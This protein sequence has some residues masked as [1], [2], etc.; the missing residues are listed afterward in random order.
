MKSGASS[1]IL[2]FIAMITL[3]FAGCGKKSPAPGTVM[4]EAMTAGRKADSFPA[5]DEDYFKDMD[6]GIQL[7][8]NEVKGRNNW[9]VW[10][11]GNDRFWDHLV[12]KSFGAVDFLK[13][14]SSH[15]NVK[16]LSRDTRWKYLGLVN[17]PCFEKANGAR[18]DR[19]GLWLDIR[20]KD[21]PPD[22]F[23]NEQKYPG[24]KIGARGKNM[25][26]GSYYGY[27]TGIVGLRLFPNPDFDEAAAKKW[28]PERFYTD[29]S[30]YNDKNLIRPYRVGMSCGFCHVGPSPV[31]PPED[32]ESP[33]WENLNSN[34]GAQYFWVDRILFWDKDESSFVY[35]LL[36]TSLPGTLD[37][38]FI[39]SD[40]INNP[41]TMN[42]LYSVGPR[43]GP[44]LRWGQEKLA[45]GNLKNKQ[46]QDFPQTAAL[47]QFYKAPD[48]V[49]TPRV[50]KDGSD[51]VGILGALNRV[52]INIGLFSEEW[53]LHFNA[54]VG[55]KEITP[56]KIEDA[57]KNS[58]YWNATVAQT[59]DV[60]LFFL[61]SAKPDLL[62]DAP[63]GSQYLTQD[64]ARLNRGKVAFAERCARCHSSKIPEAPSNVD[65][66]NWEQYW[67]WTKT[68]DFKKKMTEMVLADDFLTDNY[69][70]TERRIPVT[71]LQ[72]NACSPL[73]TNAIAGN[74][75]DNFSSQTYQTLP[76]VGKVTL[77]N[78][79]DGTT[80]DYE[81]PGGGRGFTRP[82]SLISL[83]STAPFLLNNSVG[84]FRWEASVE[85]RMDSFT[86]AIEK[87]LWPEKREKD[88]ILGDKVPGFIYRTTAT[89]YIK[90][91]PGFL[92]PRLEKL[93]SW[94]DWLYRLFP[95]LFSEGI[96]MIGPIPKGTPVTLLTNIDLE[97]NR[98]DL[99]KVLLKMKADLKQVEGASDEE[100]AKVF[101]NLVPD[102]LKVSKCPDYV[103]NKGHYFGTSSFKE[104][105]ALSDDDKW[106][107][108]E[109]LKTF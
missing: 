5:A 36:H 74:I 67:A 56:I 77:H 63:G 51:S 30:Y 41:R 71:L 13:I 7:T 84:K 94:G 90:V 81:L 96:V 103:V 15:P 14:L 91:A 79:I 46:F 78:P 21:C 44:A 8:T 100:A 87:M 32:P 109:Y 105:P 38:S 73:A 88:P 102:L 80:F 70:S 4:D 60:A 48:T 72:T 104:E 58:S 23:E 93:L 85:A 43:L 101:K 1:R 92:P 53:L 55:G 35:Q 12:N 68:D 22:P 17:E 39:S 42:A 106:A 33:K 10:T 108:I 34:P 59:A 50:L 69:L 66:R 26:V 2:I 20:S 37:T 57:E 47:S 98:A 89:S 28:D 82:P 25:P 61:K 75:W 83:W 86:D 3:V 45:G 64:K 24:V 40:Y 95:W 19:F 54:L 9:I 11:G 65:E 107:L 99:V 62:K 97:S 18:P 52:F 6:G 49:W 31:R 16:H 76:S 29:R 27:A